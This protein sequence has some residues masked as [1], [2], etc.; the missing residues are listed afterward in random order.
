MAWVCGYRASSTVA[1]TAL[2][3]QGVHL[4]QDVGWVAQQVFKMSSWEMCVAALRKVGFFV[5]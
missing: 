3:D 4:L 2:F 1:Q 5:A